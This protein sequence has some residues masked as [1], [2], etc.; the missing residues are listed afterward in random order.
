MKTNNIPTAFFLRRL[1]L[2]ADKE[3]EGTVMLK[4]S[5]CE[6]RAREIWH[7]F[8][9]A[10]ATMLVF[11]GSGRIARA[12][13]GDLDPTFGNGGKVITDISNNDNYGFAVVTQSD[14]KIIVAG[15]SGVYPVFHSA[16]AR[17]NSNGSLDQAFGNG[18]TVV[19]S[20][21]NGGDGLS[22]LVLQ[23]D[24]KIVAAGSVIHNNFTV[25]FVVA[26][27]NP[28]G[29]LDQ[30]FGNAGRNVFN[31]G[32]PE[33]E[34]NAVV[35]QAD[36]KIIV[37]G[38]SGAGSGSELNDF[39]LARLNPDGSFDQSFGNGGRVKTHFDGQYNTGSR[40]SSGVLQ[41]D[42]KLIVGGSYKTEGVAREFALARYSM[43]GSLDATFGNG[44]K[45]TTSLGAADAFGFAL[46]LHY[47]GKIVLA[48]YFDTGYHNHDFALAR[49]HANGSLDTTFGNNGQVISDL[50]GGSDDIAY[51]L[52][53]QSDGKLIAG[54]RTGQYPNFKFALAR[55][56]NDGSF[57]P[58]FG[59]GGSVLTDFGGFS[60]QS[61]S[62][63]LQ[64]D[65]KIL[66]AGYSISG[67]PGNFNTDFALAR[68][69]GA[70]QLTAAA[71]RKTHGSAGTFDVNLP[72][73]GAPGVECRDGAGNHTLV[74]SFNNQVVSG[75][76]S[77]TGGTGTISGPPIFTDNRM[78]V[79][80]TG[81]AD[82]Q[83][84]VLTLHN[85]TDNISRVLPDT[86]VSVNMLIGDTTGNNVINASDIAQVKGQSGSLVSNANF[87]EDVT[88]NGVINGSDIALVKSRSGAAIPNP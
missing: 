85:V 29:S 78:I 81:V 66:L 63:A 3:H 18:G 61:Y 5:K 37:I 51:S 25:G 79:N 1:G 22:A 49:Y 31:F 56:N 42:G 57:D 86:A 77:I 32:D 45:V 58:S 53:L 44:G 43:D 9:F 82:V 60:S 64:S 75:S 19:A 55:Y 16:L 36:G 35:L 28:D 83:T 26:R 38:V 11:S 12:A 39:A 2:G 6:T 13:D 59:N 68:Y 67:G 73:T 48:G 23:P 71:S 87:R 70:F 52:V 21:D 47:N 69:L 30:T 74:F 24:G 15:Q 17:Y 46:V 14:G 8:V 80:L 20:L 33:A 40:G 76:V 41:A 65:G 34:G 72:L 10:A 50:F 27:F 62:A 88:V 84:L 4:L 54:G 7:I